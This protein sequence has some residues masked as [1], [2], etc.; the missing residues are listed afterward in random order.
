MKTK[1]KKNSSKY[2]INTSIK[3]HQIL[4]GKPS[5]VE[6]KTTGQLQQNIH[7]KIEI[8]TTKFVLNLSPQ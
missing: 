3:E 6:E 2:H 1:K 8:T 5:G 4:R 7:Y